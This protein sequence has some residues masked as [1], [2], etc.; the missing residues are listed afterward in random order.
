MSKKSGK[1]NMF[2]MT[3]IIESIGMIEAFLEGISE[4]DVMKDKKTQS[5][6]I[7]QLE[8]IGEAVKNLPVGFTDKYSN[9]EW[10]KIAGLR[11]KLIHHYF[12]VDFE[13]VWKVTKEDI[14]KLKK[15]VKKILKK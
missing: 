10:R 12:G 15:E 13:K 7:R 6:V 9:I 14:P 3:H 2:F 11:D 4:K 5:A 8:I 1:D